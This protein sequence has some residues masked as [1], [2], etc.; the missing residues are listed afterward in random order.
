MAEGPNAD[1][2]GSHRRYNPLL[3]EW[4]LCSPQ[5]LERPWQGRVEP[6]APPARA[7]Y[8]PDCYLCPGNARARGERNPGYAHTFAFD[9]DFPALD[10][11]ARGAAHDDELLRSVPESGRCRVL[12]FTP[13]HDLSLSR[14]PVRDIA[15]VVDAWAAECEALAASPGIGYVQLFENRG[16][17]MGCSNPHPH[18]QLWATAHVPT[19]PAKKAATQS[20]YFEAH[21][22]DL[23]GDYLTRELADGSRVVLENEHW[24][25]L[26]PF[27]AVWPFQTMMLP[28]RRVGALAQL[29]A[30][31]RAAL[32]AALQ[33]LTS[34]YDNL[35]ACEF[36]YSMG[37]A[38]APVGRENDPSWRLHAEL[39]P[40]LLRSATVRKFIVGYELMAEPQRDLTAEAAAARLRATPAAPA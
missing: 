39:L 32:A 17:L 9:N 21:G 19:I 2:A 37:W 8:E 20:R 23:L 28:R 3:E 35:F 13:R 11:I 14:M 26:V 24:V 1:R 25:V 15:L 36:P 18:A 6:F 4:V 31:E 7:A 22:S 38:A 30:D 33:R 5:R 12:C 10:G 29:S 34:R 27:W 16:E 40:P